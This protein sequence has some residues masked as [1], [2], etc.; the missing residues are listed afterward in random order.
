M[1]PSGAKKCFTLNEMGVDKINLTYIFHDAKWKIDIK[2]AHY[3]W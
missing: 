1:R 3:Q 2:K